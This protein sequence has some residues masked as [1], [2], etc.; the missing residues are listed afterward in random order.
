MTATRSDYDESQL[1]PLP[2]QSV[3]PTAGNDLDSDNSENVLPITAETRKALVVHPQV[4]PPQVPS[5]EQR[6]QT[7]VVMRLVAPD[8]VPS[9]HHC[10]HR[11]LQRFLTDNGLLTPVEE[12]VYNALNMARSPWEIADLIQ[13]CFTDDK[14]FRFEWGN[15]ETIEGRPRFET[16]IKF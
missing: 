13:S 14:I 15:V 16:A 1:P 2:Q 7:I 9:G 11:P 4:L 8:G 3:E 10:H 6:L 5:M 12:Q